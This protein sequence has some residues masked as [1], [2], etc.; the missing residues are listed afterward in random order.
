MG[1][2]CCAATVYLSKRG[3]PPTIFYQEIKGTT[4]DVQ[5][6]YIYIYMYMY[7]YKYVY[8]YTYV[9]IYIY[10]Y[11]YVCKKYESDTGHI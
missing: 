11:I 10:I 2:N 8:I 3:F 1:K 5:V 4:L 6:I 9:C 7:K